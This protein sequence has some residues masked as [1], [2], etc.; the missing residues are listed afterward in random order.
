[1]AG[2]TLVQ[3]LGACPGSVR[4]AWL[5]RWWDQPAEVPGSVPARRQLRRG[6]ARTCH[7]EK[8]EILKGQPY[9]S[10]PFEFPVSVCSFLSYCCVSA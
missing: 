6:M 4:T 8:S 5:R 9:S 1:M 2:V 7:G 3:D 10:Q